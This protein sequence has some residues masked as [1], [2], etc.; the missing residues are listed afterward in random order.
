LGRLPVHRWDVS[1]REALIIQKS[2]RP[3]VLVR[4]LKGLIRT[5]AGVDMAYTSNGKHFWA[6]VCLW[7]VILEQVLEE[8]WIRGRVRF[9]YIPGLL[10]FREAPGILEVLGLLQRKPDAVLCDGQGIAHPRGLG[11]ASHVG[12]F[13]QIPT[14]GCAKRRLVGQHTEVGPHKGDQCPLIH[15]GRVLG[16]VLRTRERVKPVFVSPGNNVSVARASSLVLRCCTRYR[17]PE[18]LR[19]AHLLAGRFRKREEAS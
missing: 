2:L 5:V 15:R 4:D 1:P 3:R 16:A 19:R 12:L 11:L 17:I 13:L 7:D 8:R 10:S 18:P 9:P 14:V 6:A